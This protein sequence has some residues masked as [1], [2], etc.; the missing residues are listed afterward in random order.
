MANLKGYVAMDFF[1]AG[2]TQ[3]DLMKELVL[4]QANRKGTA[5]EAGPVEIK[6]GSIVGHA[7]GS[8]I[9]QNE[10]K[11]TGEMR[12]SILL[13][14]D[15]QVTSFRTGE[16]KDAAG[17]YVP[18]FFSKLVADQISK[19]AGG[20]LF[21]ITIGIELTNANIPTAWT[22]ERMLGRDPE[23]P[24]AQLQA[25]LKANGYLGSTYKAPMQLTG[26]GAVIEGVAEES[27][28]EAGDAAHEEEAKTKANRKFGKMARET[29]TV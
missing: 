14:G 6:M 24:M 20:A 16:V 7:F 8:E 9:K 26:P 10:D 18:S 4:L 2:K 11:Q 5:D 12:T 22:V 3:N 28:T 15:F 29:E 1:R 27:E 25:K 23:S 19:E 17:I 21:A 13:T